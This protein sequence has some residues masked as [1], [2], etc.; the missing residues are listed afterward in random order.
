MWFQQYTVYK[1]PELVCIEHKQVWRYQ[2]DN[3]KPEIE[4][5]S[6]LYLQCHCVAKKRKK[7]SKT[8]AH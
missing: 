1:F 5:H 6:I 7:K 8:I 3:Q 2:G 4:G